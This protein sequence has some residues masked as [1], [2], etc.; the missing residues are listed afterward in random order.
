M[1]VR[2]AGLRLEYR[3]IQGSADRPTVVFMH[4]GL[5][6]VST[7]R[8]IPDQVAARTGCR[9]VAY[10]RWGHGAS[11]SSPAPRGVRFM[12]D[13]ALRVLPQVLDA[14][15]V[16]NPILVGHSDGGSIAIIHSGAAIR[17]TR[18]L[19]LLAPHVFVEDLSVASI[20][21]VRES[22]GSSD[23][24]ERMWRHHGD[25]VDG[26]FRGWADVWLDP[27]FRSWNIE[28]YLPRIDRPVLVIQGEDDEFGTRRQVEAIERQVRG[29]VEAVML[30]QC[31]HAPHRDQPEVVVGLICEFVIR[32]A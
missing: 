14:L 22:F 16:E 25:N 29:E 2:A 3:E 27:A 11:E 4:D 21:A 28:E 26:T 20:T 9:V 15:D 17:P 18:A 19:V 31:G 8:D 13:E 30:P 1:F 24:R 7:W 12:H 23:L 6:S 5:G 10:S 32:E